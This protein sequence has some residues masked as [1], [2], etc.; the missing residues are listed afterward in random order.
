MFFGIW[1]FSLSFIDYL[2]VRV[3]LILY[4]YILLKHE[5]TGKQNVKCE[6]NKAQVLFDPNTH[7]RYYN[8]HDAP[9]SGTIS[10][11]DLDP[12]WIV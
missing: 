10:E 12:G 8:V 2:I 1:R 5:I 11:G 3:L 9:S 7:C 4:T 6:N